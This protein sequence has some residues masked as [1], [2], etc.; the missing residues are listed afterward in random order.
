MSPVSTNKARHELL[1]EA[2][3]IAAILLE[4]DPVDPENVPLDEQME[5]VNQLF[6]V[7]DRQ[8]LDR[9]AFARG[10]GFGIA[11]GFFMYKKGDK[12]DG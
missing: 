1:A 12:A 7:A 5:L 4:R 8:E 10:A 3:R 11:V 2:R 6:R 9:N